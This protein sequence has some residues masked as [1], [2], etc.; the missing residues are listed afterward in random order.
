MDRR[1]S[2]GGAAL[3]A[4]AAVAGVFACCLLLQLVIGQSG[5][6]A[7]A[8]HRALATA[9]P[10]R[11]GSWGTSARQTPAVVMEGEQLPALEW[12]S[13]IEAFHIFV[14]A[15]GEDTPS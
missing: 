8:Q 3:L 9:L 5:S 14:G 4:L 2:S 6:P 15:E 7:P 12:R 1:A 11:R 13:D 10:E